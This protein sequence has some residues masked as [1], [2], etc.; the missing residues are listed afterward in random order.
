VGEREPEGMVAGDRITVN[1]EELERY[2]YQASFTAREAYRTAIAAIEVHARQEY[3]SAFVDLDDEQQDEVVEALED[4][5]IEIFDHEPSTEQFFEMLLR[6]TAEGTFGDPMYGGNRRMMGWEMLGY[7]GA[8]REYSP[9]EMLEGTDRPSQSLAHLT[10]QHPGHE[11]HPG[12]ALPVAGSEP[13]G[14]HTRVRGD[15]FLTPAREEDVTEGG[16]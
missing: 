10:P 16:S 11:T 3:G 14:P 9:R 7:P 1:E 6:H 2:G 15:G 4:G 8:Q 13:D 5:E 12:A